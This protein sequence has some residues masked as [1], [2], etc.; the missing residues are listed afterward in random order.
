[1]LEEKRRLIDRAI[2]A[3]AEA[4]AVLA[5]NPTSTAPILQK[6]IRAM[7]MQDIDMMRRYY[8]DEAWEKWKHHYE[9]WP[10]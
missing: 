10:A 7:E 4:D 9:D 1:M 6:V 5:S 2:Q 3:L 8:T